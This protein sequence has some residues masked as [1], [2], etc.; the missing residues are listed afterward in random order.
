MTR[1]GMT[2]ASAFVFAL[3][4]MC[5]DAAA[6]RPP[7][8]E[9]QLPPLTG[10]GGQPP[11]A[12]RPISP[13]T[14]QS[15]GRPTLQVPGQPAFQTPMAGQG[16]DP[17]RAILQTPENDQILRGTDA[18]TP[19]PAPSAAQPDQPTPPLNASPQP[20]WANRWVPTASAK[21]QALDKVS[22]QA[23]A[24]TLKVG[25]PANFGSLTIEVKACLVRPPDQPADAAAYLNV[26]DN[27]ADA[28]G[29]NG[30]ML[31]NEPAVSMMQNP[32]Y[33]LRVTGCG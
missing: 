3:A 19:P 29:F 1:A 4:L 20:Q 21:I 5:A 18:Q 24:L 2:R 6:Q 16:P 9:M 22:A 14:T 10:P 26:T 25:Q 33:D 30:W 15:P 28:P 32:I 7:I 13:P 11:G 12:S 8:Q 31:A 17:S 23:T 27:H